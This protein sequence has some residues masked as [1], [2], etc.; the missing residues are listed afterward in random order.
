M[1]F[2]RGKDTVVQ[3]KSSTAVLSL[4]W[5]SR[6]RR[7]HQVFDE[8][9][10]RTFTE[11]IEDLARQ[12]GVEVPREQV[13]AQRM[14]QDAKRRSDKQRAIELNGRVARLYSHL[15]ADDE[16]GRAAREYLASRG[17]S[18]PLWQTFQLG[19][20]PQSGDLVARK[21]QQNGI[22]PEFAHRLGLVAP[23]RHGGGYH[24]RFWGRLMFAVHGVGG[25]VIGFGGRLLSADKTAK[26]PKYINTPETLLYHK[27]DALYGLW[28]ASK[29]MRQRGEAIIVEGNFDVIQLH[30]HGFE[31]AIA[32]MGTAL[33][34]QQVRLIKRFAERVVA[35]FDGDS[36][37]QK[38]AEKAIR[39]LLAA[40]LQVRIG[41]LPAG[42]D[43]D[44]ILAK[45]GRDAL[46]EILQRAR[47]ALDFLID[48]RLKGAE[49]EAQQ[50]EMGKEIAG[51]IQLLPDKLEREIYV[52]KL[53]EWTGISRESLVDAVKTASKNAPRQP[54]R[55]QPP[56]FE[57]GGP[58]AKGKVNE[59]SKL[60]AK[61]Q[62][63]FGILLAHPRL[64]ARTERENISGLLTNDD[65]RAT[66][67]AAARMQA[68][69]GRI[70]VAQ[71]LTSAPPTIRDA[72]AQA[73]QRTDF[74]DGDPNRALDDWLVVAIYDRLKHARA[75]I[76]RRIARAE[77]QGEDTSQLTARMLE[78]QGLTKRCDSA[79]RNRQ[80]DEVR[81]LIPE[82]IHVEREIHDTQ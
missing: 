7:C 32:P 63:F 66:Y 52:G 48:Q 73:A 17:I 61:Y 81:A 62:D 72:V 57:G 11:V 64:F 76:K 6:E 1:S 22:D 77:R 71:L 24:D 5:L 79:R 78:L 53:T 16:Q 47:H 19:Y 56:P 8:G 9:G 69:T 2:S 26:S 37:G 55:Q 41:V 80:L 29:A 33:T 23:R 45:Q 49:T 38:A 43:P 74:A 70:D 82:L 34:E 44:S 21:L 59:N 10:G 51:L 30:Q 58:P 14:A 39:V 42:E 27:S 28:Q 12:G 4:L 67:A 3:R 20:A 36:A 75:Q 15:L 65:V 50:A 46:V 31:N 40:G 68:D 25:D 54:S 18:Q 13:S 35:I 60:G